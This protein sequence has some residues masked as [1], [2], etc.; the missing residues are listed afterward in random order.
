MEGPSPAGSV[1]AQ[2][3]GEGE[4][5]GG[6][7]VATMTISMPEDRLSPQSRKRCIREV[8]KGAGEI[9]LALGFDPAR[10]S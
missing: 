8:M 6:E 4:A 5:A 2:Q 9:S 3:E 10:T 7:I 1:L